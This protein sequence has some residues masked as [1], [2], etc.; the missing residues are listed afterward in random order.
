M[1]IRIKVGEEESTTAPEG[2]TIRVGEQQAPE[3][4]LQVSLQARKTLDGH[5]MI[6]DHKDIDIVMMPK[7]N[8][9]VAFPKESMGSHVYE[10]QDRLF[11]FLFKKGVIVLDS[12]QGGNVFSSMEARLAES[13]E[14]NT[15]QMTLL[16]IG[17]FIED[18]KPLYEFEK[19]FEEEEERRLLEPDP[20]ESTEF[21]PEKYHDAEKG[22]MRDQ[23]AFG[24]A[25][26]YR[27]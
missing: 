19:A 20:E 13:K 6:F 12:V 5:I 7:E 9:I 22:T 1:A 14:Y 3:P 8:K 16:T 27:M 18:E 23:K 11:K 2:L 4:T 26:I 15:V 10:V 17:K 25:N 21:D 24:V